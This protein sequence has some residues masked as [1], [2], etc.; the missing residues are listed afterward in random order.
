MQK[1]EEVLDKN[2]WRLLDLFMDLDKNKDWKLQESDFHREC[3]QLG[4]TDAMLDELLMAYGSN[5]KRIKYKELAKG[6]T[7]LIADK[8]NSIKESSSN[9]SINSSGGFLPKA[10]LLRFKDSNSDMKSQSI[11][12]QKEPLK[13]QPIIKEAISERSDVDIDEF[14]GNNER[15]LFSR[16]D[17]TISR[18]SSDSNGFLRVPSIDSRETFYPPV[19]TENRGTSAPIFYSIK[20]ASRPPTA[21]TKDKMNIAE[22][23]VEFRNKVK[24]DTDNLRNAYGSVDL[25][26]QQFKAFEYPQ[27]IEKSKIISDILD[28]Q[29]QAREM[30]VLEEKK[31]WERKRL[32]MKLKMK[33]KI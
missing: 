23:I 3:T 21:K 17:S 30:K 8:R 12:L 22:M 31:E 2:K 6:R 18:T 27:D 28:K 25:S 26:E 29:R 16:Q 15:V 7:D 33:N 14:R 32:R 20:Y 10:G 24:V 9:F 19:N 13:T 11:D 5:Q 4:I 1:I